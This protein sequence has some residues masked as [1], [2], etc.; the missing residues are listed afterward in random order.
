MLQQFGIAVGVIT[1]LSSAVMAVVP[2]VLS[3][4]YVAYLFVL[5]FF[6]FI[7]AIALFARSKSAFAD[8]LVDT[9]GVQIAVAP[10]MNKATWIDLAVALLW[11]LTAIMGL[12]LLISGKSRFRGSRVYA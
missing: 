12:V 1:F 3:Y 10:A 2:L 11:L 8:Y 7:L 6:L 4:S 9:P 5:D